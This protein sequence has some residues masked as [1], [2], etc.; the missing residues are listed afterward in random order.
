MHDMRPDYEHNFKGMT[1]EPVELADLLA[2]REQ[3]L[4]ELQRGLDADERRF[5]HSL[6]AGRPEWR[7]LGSA[8]LEHLP[9]IRWKLRN[10]E[11]LGKT[12]AGKFAAQAAVLADLLPP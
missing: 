8:H 2:V 9:G 7:L 6:V 12:N 4:G 3:M 10:L 11:Q 5:L 1:A